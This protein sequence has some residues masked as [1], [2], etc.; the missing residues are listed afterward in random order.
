MTVAVERQVTARRGEVPLG[1]TSAGLDVVG[2]SKRFG[3]VRALDG[4]NVSIAP[5]TIHALIGENGAGKSTLGKIIS[6]VLQP[7]RGHIAIAGKP[8]VLKSPREALALGIATIEQEVSLAPNLSVQDNVFLGVEP[9]RAGVINRRGLRQLWQGAVADLGFHVPGS[10]LV[11]ELPLGSRQQVEILRAISRKADLIVMDEPTAALGKDESLA[12]QRDMRKLRDTGVSILVI[13]HFIKEVLALADLVTVL[14]DGRVVRTAPARE[15]TDRSLIEAMLGRPL[16]SVFPKKLAA[17]TS[18]SVV[19]EG[20]ELVGGGLN[21]ISLGVRGGEIVGVAGLDG[22]GRVEAGRALFGALPLVS[23]QVRVAGSTVSTPSPRESIRRGVSLI[24]PSR[25]DDGLFLDRPIEENA[26]ISC[27]GE[28]SRAGVVRRR[29]ERRRVAQTLT[30]LGVPV[31]RR[32]AVATLSGGNQQKVLFARALM[33]DPLA[34]IAI[35]PTRGIDIG[36]KASIY[37]LLASL[38]KSGVGILLISSEQDELIGLAHRILVLNQGRLTAELAGPE[39]TEE[40]ILSAAFSNSLE[41]KG[42]DND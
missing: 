30:D 34:L 25:R 1:F 36:A 35:E 42:G 11:G 17:A 9:R 33:R 3:G 16:S 22:S 12:L 5:R 40:R 8:L 29:A 7:D 21:G 13:S 41:L 31:R 37:S 23:G 19:L 18:R 20:R 28:I 24:P 26:T 4:V 14:R 15:E 6:G 38:A 2:I 27:V 10:E 39:M 32:D